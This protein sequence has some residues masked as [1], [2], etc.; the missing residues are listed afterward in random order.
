MS[1][2]DTERKAEMIMQILA[3][4]GAICVA[5]VVILLIAVIAAVIKDDYKERKYKKSYCLLTGEE[6]IY[7]ADC[8]TCVECPICEEAKEKERE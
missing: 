4:I 2:S 5:S 7:A 6:C 8:E 1:E 3:T